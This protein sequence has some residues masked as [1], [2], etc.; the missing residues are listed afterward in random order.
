MRRGNVVLIVAP[1]DIGK[2]RPAVIVQS[3]TLGDATT[4]VIVCPMSS[5]VAGLGRLRPTVEATPLSG[6]RARSQIMTD[7]IMALRRDRVRA[8][9]GHL[10]NEQMAQLDRAMLV[11]LGL[12]E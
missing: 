11:V 2:P 6:L 7:K 10:G 5:E 1:G 9:L 12:A 4:S 3:D 8:V